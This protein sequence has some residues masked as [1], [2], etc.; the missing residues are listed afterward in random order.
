MDTVTQQNAALVE[1]MAAAAS[2]LQSQAQDL[3]TVVAVFNL[4]EGHNATK[5]S[6]VSDATRSKQ[7][8]GRVSKLTHK[9]NVTGI[10]TATQTNGSDPKSSGSSIY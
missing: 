2:G 1:E 9:F 7:F 5:I 6:T 4:G 8:V 3:V 10:A